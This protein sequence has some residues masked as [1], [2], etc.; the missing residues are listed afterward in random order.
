MRGECSAIINE[1]EEIKIRVS[2]GLQPR[3]VQRQHSEHSQSECLQT[4]APDIRWM[5]MK[6]TKTMLNISVGDGG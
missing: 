3:S 2:S 5:K 4:R 1:E 6:P